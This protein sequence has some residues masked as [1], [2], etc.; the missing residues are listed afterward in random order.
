MRLPIVRSGI[1]RF[2]LL[3]LL[4]ALVVAGVALLAL[5][6]ASPDGDVE[7]LLPPPTPVQPVVVYITGAVGREGLYSMRE[8]DRA[9]DAIELAGGLVG[10]ADRARVNGASLLRDGD[11][12]HVPR[13]A[14]PAVVTPP[15]STPAALVN[16]NTATQKAL[17]AL[18]EIGPVTAKAILDYR[19]KIRRFTSVEQLLDVKGIGAVT[20]ARL[21]PLVEA[22]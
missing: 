15:G 14:E 17:E 3:A 1:V 8:G 12:I 22:R 21:R 20:L 11:H 5:R 13:L 19:A 16:L 7:I 4:L 9:S 18:P 2:G 10:D 6:S